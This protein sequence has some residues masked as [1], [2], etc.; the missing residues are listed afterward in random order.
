MTEYL[1][2]LPHI[3]KKFNLGLDIRNKL[4]Y[5]SNGRPMSPIEVK[6]IFDKYYPMV[7]EEY[8]LRKI[9]EEFEPPV[10]EKKTK[11]KLKEE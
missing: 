4:V 7:K 1:K 3:N 6:E 5:A 9:L 11:V 2:L 8:L 10:K